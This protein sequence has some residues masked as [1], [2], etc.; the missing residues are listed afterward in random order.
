[1]VTIILHLD[2]AMSEDRR[3]TRRNKDEQSVLKLVDIE[4]LI[5][6]S[7]R[8]ALTAFQTDIEKFID[9]RLSA[10][11]QKL[12]IFET[13]CA[14]MEKSI[15]ACHENVKSVEERKPNWKKV[16]TVKPCQTIFTH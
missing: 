7:L 8:K 9:N 11:G 13:R 1:M 6:Q 12:A 16:T 4:K 10:I 15:E 14:D 5:D 2:H 3:T